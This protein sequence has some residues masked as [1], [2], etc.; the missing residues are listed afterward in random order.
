MAMVR[1]SR[2][3]RE[4]NDLAEAVVLLKAPVDGGTPVASE[5]RAAAESVLAKVSEET[6]IIPDASS[7]FDAL[8]SFSVRAPRRFIDAL[9]H[10]DGVAQVLPNWTPGSALIE[11]VEKSRVKMP[12]A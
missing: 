4:S 7:V 3:N 10:A 9:A 6:G 8:H 5:S 1:K 11:P 12:D 2:P